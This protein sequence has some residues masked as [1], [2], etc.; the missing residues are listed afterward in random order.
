MDKPKQ[1]PY[2]EVKLGDNLDHI[3]SWL[4][5]YEGQVLKVYWKSGSWYIRIQKAEKEIIAPST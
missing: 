1:K 5:T 2:R 3:H 4:T